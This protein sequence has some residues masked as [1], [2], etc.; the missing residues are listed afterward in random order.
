[1]IRNSSHRR[2]YDQHET[3]IL[4]PNEFRNITVK[5][6]NITSGFKLFDNSDPLIHKYYSPLEMAMIDC[7]YGIFN[8]FTKGTK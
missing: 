5:E 3:C 6:P 7:Q 8:N 2:I 4:S 1:M